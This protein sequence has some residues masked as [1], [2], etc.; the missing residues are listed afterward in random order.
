VA[1]ATAV[2]TLGPLETALFGPGGAV[3]ITTPQEVERVISNALG[4]V[5]SGALPPARSKAVV[6]LLRVRIELA[7]LAISERLM[8][9]EKHLQD[10]QD[11]KAP[12]RGRKRR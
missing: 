5:L 10:Q 7:S 9:L 6:D 12:G 3:A 4:A 11:Q 2:A 8:R 1:V